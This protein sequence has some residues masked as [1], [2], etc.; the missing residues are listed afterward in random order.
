MKK[1][2][3]IALSVWYAKNEKIN[4]GRFLKHNSNHQKQ[5]VILMILNGKAWPYLAVKKLSA[6][7]KRNN[8]KK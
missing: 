2:L 3:I 6:L 5:V 1:T 4:P 8:F 7:L